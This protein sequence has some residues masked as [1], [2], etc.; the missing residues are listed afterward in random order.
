IFPSINRNTLMES[1]RVSTIA[2]IPKQSG[3]MDGA[4]NEA[5]F[6]YPRGVAVDEKGNVFVT[7]SGNHSVRKISKDGI[8]STLA[9][10]KG[11][12]GYRDGEGT[13]ALF[14][15]TQGIALFERNLYITDSKRDCIRKIS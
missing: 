5:T 10:Q 1:L 15:S 4:T 9:G 12:P 11:D 3:Y 14:R 7:D 8:V 6:C 2:G 13:N